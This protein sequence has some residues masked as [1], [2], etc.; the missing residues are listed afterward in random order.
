MISDPLIHTILDHSYWWDAVE[1]AENA[2]TEG[3]VQGLGYG[4]CA[5]RSCPA[6]HGP[7]RSVSL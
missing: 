6:N 3:G 5:G 7:D 4:G 2:G 1:L